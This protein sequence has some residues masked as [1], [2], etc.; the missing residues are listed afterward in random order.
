MQ[1]SP[2]LL[3]PLAAMALLVCLVWLSRRRRG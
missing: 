2:E 1:L 3:M